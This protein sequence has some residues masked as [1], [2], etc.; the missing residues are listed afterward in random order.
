LALA[1]LGAGSIAADW[2][3]RGQRNVRRR[4]ALR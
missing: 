4:E 3:F 2:L 1:L